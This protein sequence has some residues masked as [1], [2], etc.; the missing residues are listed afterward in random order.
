MTSVCWRSPVS[1]L[2]HFSLADAPVHLYL[3]GHRHNLQVIEGREPGP[4]LHVIAGSGS[5]I[6]PVRIGYANRRFAS[7]RTGFVRVD[8]VGRGAGQ[9]ARPSGPSSTARQ[10]RYSSELPWP[11]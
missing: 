8:L 9:R 3:A 10:S 11:E 6:R 7:E 1:P 5:N 2:E 4:A